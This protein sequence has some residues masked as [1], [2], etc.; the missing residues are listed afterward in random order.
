MAPE[1]AV[2]DPHLDHRVDIYA[3]GVLGYELLTGQPPFR[4]PPQEVLVAQV[5]RPPEPITTHRP[6]IPPALA[7][8][9]MKCLE[10]RPADRWQSAE[11]LVRQLEA[12]ATLSQDTTMPARTAAPSPA[13]L[14]KRGVPS[15]LGWAGAGAL[16]VAGAVALFLRQSEPELLRLGNR[17]AVASAPEW[18]IHPSLSPDG[19]MLAYTSVG[20]APPRLLLHQ[21]GGGNPVVVSQAGFG[22]AF[23][24]DGTRLLAVTPRGLEIMPALGGQSRVVAT[25]TKWG[26]WSP[27]G[28]AIVY[29]AGDTLW[30]Q[31]ADSSRRTPIATG[32]DLHSPSWSSDGRWIAYVEGN[33]LFHRNGNLGASGIRVVSSSGGTPIGVTR[34]S[35]LNTNPIWLP[36]RPALLYISDREGGRDIYEVALTSRGVPRA[37]PPGSPPAST[38]KGSPSRPTAGGWPGPSSGKPPMSGRCRFRPATRFHSPGPP[39]SPPGPRVSKASSSHPMASGSTTTRIAPATRTSTA[40]DVSSGGSTEQL[41]TDPSADFSPAV[42]PDGREVAFHSL[43]TGNRDVFVMPAAG[44]EAVQVTRSRE[45][46]YNPTWSPDGRQLAFD[47]QRNPDQ[48]LWITRRA[49]SGEWTS[50]EPF[51]HG[52]RAARP[53]WSPDGRWISFI[54]PEGVNTSWRW[55]PTALASCSRRVTKSTRPP[56][57]RGRTT[58][59][60]SYSRDPTRWESSASSPSPSP[61]A[62]RRRRSSALPMFRVVSSIAMASRHRGAGS[63]SPGGAE[64]GCVGGG[65]RAM[66]EGAGAA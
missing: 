22:A 24:P 52:C 51:P 19:K 5:T 57:R 28:R 61:A 55:A 35:G 63:F 6:T 40:G 64:L 47:Q 17:S 50:P 38:S 16:V 34:V 43:R 4:G 48:G 21:I 65:D 46:D 18:E 54:S 20:N 62:V 26:N 3:V 2:A 11:E 25:T 10:K 44:G 14:P 32:W 7:G 45:Q 15:W 8:I 23:S 27:D 49:A 29:P 66:R 37:I 9:L 30:V 60:P 59:G 39:R 42:S 1:Q 33:S 36:G 56:G 13:G 31:A 53:R 41:T 12:H 58:A